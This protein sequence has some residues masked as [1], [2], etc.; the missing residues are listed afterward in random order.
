MHYI[1]RKPNTQVKI[2]H[3]LYIQRAGQ[4][5]F[6]SID[7]ISHGETSFAFRVIAR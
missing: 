3:I 1:Y 4:T 7:T 6:P 2:T 5:C